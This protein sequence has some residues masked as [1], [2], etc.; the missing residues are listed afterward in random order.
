M[1]V[2]AS[3]TIIGP[4]AVSLPRSALRHTQSHLWEPLQ[5]GGLMLVTQSTKNVP[6]QQESSLQKRV[7]LMEMIIGRPA[8]FP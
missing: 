5:G 8:E 4:Q 1:P 3:R 7:A 2:K 6:R